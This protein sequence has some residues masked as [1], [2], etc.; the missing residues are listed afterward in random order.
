MLVKGGPV[1]STHHRLH[2]ASESEDMLSFHEVQNILPY[3]TAHYGDQSECL[4]FE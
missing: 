2:S 1:I 3:V 4:L